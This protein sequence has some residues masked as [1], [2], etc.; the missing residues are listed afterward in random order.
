MRFEKSAL[1]L[2]VSIFFIGILSF[3]IYKK[4]KE[5]IEPATNWIG[6]KI[7]FSEELK[8]LED[9]NLYS[10]D[11]FK[12]ISVSKNKIISII[13][14]SCSKCILG[15]L[16][17]IDSL[18]AGIVNGDSNTELVF[19]LNVD[20][21]DFKSF[22]VALYPLIISNAPI[23]CDNYFR[24]E[25]ENDILTPNLSERTFLIN[26]ENKIIL[27]GNPLFYPDIIEEYKK[28]IKS[29]NN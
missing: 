14:A 8:L 24:F 13:D 9:R 11:C 20:D 5:N 7:Y 16:N 25:T 6:K 2:F 1:F 12:E 10:L 22:M 3:T 28:K 26:R 19:V 21:N 4:A 17:K 29:L 23:L 18:F 27:V 15:Q